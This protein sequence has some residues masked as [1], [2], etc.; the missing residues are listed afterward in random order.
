MSA[1][2]VLYS[3]EVDQN[4]GGDDNQ[5]YPR[6]VKFLAF[7]EN[8]VSH[9]QG[10]KVP[11]FNT[12]LGLLS[13]QST[14]IRLLTMAALFSSSKSI[15]SLILRSSNVIDTVIADPCTCSHQNTKIGAGC[16][17]CNMSLASSETSAI[18]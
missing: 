6:L 1:Q 9:N 18:S 7:F 17:C 11:T 4:I 13:E 10:C 12:G 2:Q 14:T 5:P 8:T 3:P 15:M 16:P